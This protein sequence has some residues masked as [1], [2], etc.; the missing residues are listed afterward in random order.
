MHAIT[1]KVWKFGHNVDTDAIVPG[2]YLDAPV[3]EVAAHALAG[4]RPEFPSRVRPGDLIVA[5]S[6]FGCGSSREHAASV[7]KHLG[8]GLVLAESFGRIFFRNA[9]AVGL[10]VLACPGV[11]EAFEDGQTA[12]VR[13]D[14]VLVTN[15]ETGRE[16]RG[17]ALSEQML[18]ILEKGGILELLKEHQ[19]V[20]R[21]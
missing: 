3:Q 8:L 16:L 12:S 4:L 20:K 17:E 18:L 2:Q 15:R 21:D 5:G 9:I 19:G 11:H 6:N 13:L 7:L 14:Q 10:P 1:G